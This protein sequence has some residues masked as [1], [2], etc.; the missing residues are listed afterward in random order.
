[1]LYMYMYV[2]I[3]VYVHICRKVRV[4]TCIYGG[5]FKDE[6]FQYKH[7][8]PFLLSMANK[9]PN[10]N[11]SQF[12]MQIIIVVHASHFLFLI[13][14]HYVVCSVFLSSV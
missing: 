6:N 5:T 14:A 1:M 8:Q 11:G 13:N 3:C 2:H 4:Y 12:F 7:D 9:G 10:T